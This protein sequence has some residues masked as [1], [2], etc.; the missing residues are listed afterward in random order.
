M[1]ERTT[2]DES[3]IRSQI[4]DLTHFPIRRLDTQIGVT[5]KEDLEEEIILAFD[6]HGIEIPFPHRTLYAGSVT[7]PFPVKIVDGQGGQ[8]KAPSAH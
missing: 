5:C 6:Q 8:S 1:E 3:I 2:P 4:I 7:D